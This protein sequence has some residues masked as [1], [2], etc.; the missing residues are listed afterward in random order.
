MAAN[1]RETDNAYAYAFPLKEKGTEFKCAREN[2][3]F[4]K[5]HIELERNLKIDGSIALFIF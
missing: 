2:E 5:V 1:S 4:V 3:N